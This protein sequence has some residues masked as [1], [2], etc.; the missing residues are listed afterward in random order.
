MDLR[1]WHKMPPVAAAMTPF[2]FHVQAE[3][4]ITEVERLMEE[5]EIRHVPVQSDGH[6]VGIISE[7]DLH[8]LVNPSLPTVDKRRIKAR[9]VLVSSPYIVEVGTPL[10]EV[11][12]EMARRHIGSAIV[13]KNGKLAGIISVTDVCRVL[14]EIL[15]HR[16]PDPSDAA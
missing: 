11:V 12:A 15:R 5:Q 2:P 3:D 7:R 14:A 9:D 16:F 1:N 6:V 10:D 8:H 13:V 4:S